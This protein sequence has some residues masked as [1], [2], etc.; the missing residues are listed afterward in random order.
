M[1]T[2]TSFKPGQSG[3]PAGKPKGATNKDTSFI[4]EVLIRFGGDNAEKLQGWLNEVA[5]KD[6]A[7]AFELYLKALEFGIPKLKAI[8]HSGKDGEGLNF[9]VRV[10]DLKKDG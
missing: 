5:S 10:E 2:K 1:K 6:P 7:K 8:E 9:I 4:R 3:N